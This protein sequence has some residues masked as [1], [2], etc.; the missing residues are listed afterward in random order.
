MAT[1]QKFHTQ[2]IPRKISSLIDPDFG[3]PHLKDL[4]VV[5]W[6]DMSVDNTRVDSKVTVVACSSV[7]QSL[8]AAS[9]EK[10]MI[11]VFHNSGG[12]EETASRAML[13]FPAQEGTAR[14]LD[15]VAITG[16]KFVEEHV[17]V[18]S[19]RDGTLKLWDCTNL[20]RINQA[21]NITSREPVTA[22]TVP[23]SPGSTIIISGTSGGSVHVRDIRFHSGETDKGMKARSSA[24]TSL[25]TGFNEYEVIAGDKDGNIEIWDSR[26]ASNMPLLSLNGMDQSIRSGCIPEL[27]PQRPKPAKQH[28]I[29]EDMWDLAMGRKRKSNKQDITEP[30]I[31]TS[32]N[33]PIV[34]GVREKAH[35]DKV[36]ALGI[37]DSGVLATVSED[38][39]AKVFCKLTGNLLGVY[40]LRDKPISAAFHGGMLCIGKR[41]GFELVESIT[42]SVS[43]NYTNTS[44]HIGH[45]NAVAFAGDWGVCTGGMDRHVFI[46][47]IET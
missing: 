4:S 9:T 36:V 29:S 47:R 3:F 23:T 21:L 14:Q 20:S 38:K 28:S 7:H 45:V 46:H 39:S 31:S 16:L 11:S 27:Y 8:V 26:S 43:S 35:D 19:S 37:V 24:I 1:T 44:T 34:I 25:C 10:G 15:K 18:S 6:G 42:S 32:A 13:R 22:L 17:L 30:W 40:Q 5:R 12:W 41:Q 33:P 2:L